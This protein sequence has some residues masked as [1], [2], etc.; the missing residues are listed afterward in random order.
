MMADKK[1]LIIKFQSIFISIFSFLISLKDNIT[2][3]NHH[4]IVLITAHMFH[5]DF[6]KNKF[7][8][9]FI[10]ADIHRI[11]TLCLIF[12]SPASI[13]KFI[14]S[15][16]FKKMKSHPTCNKYQE[17]INLLPKSTNATL[18]PNK[19]IKTHQYMPKT[20]KYFINILNIME[21]FHFS[22]F[23]A[24]SVVI[25]NKNPNIGHIKIL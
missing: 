10:Q 20:P 12:P 22:F 5:K 7:N 13:G 2:I 19:H 18:G 3:I 17:G 9:K 8:T 1:F 6:I 15:S 14:L 16:I 4:T 11:F 21:S 24:N 25:G 23:S